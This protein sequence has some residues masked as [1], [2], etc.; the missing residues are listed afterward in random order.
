MQLYRGASF[1]RPDFCC[2][3]GYRGNQYIRLPLHVLLR[4]CLLMH[5]PYF[6]LLR[7]SSANTSSLVILTADYINTAVF[8]SAKPRVM[9]GAKILFRPAVFGAMVP[10]AL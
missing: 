7:S 10:L 3:Y 4:V 1:F 2:T 6:V 9:A 5:Q 8:C